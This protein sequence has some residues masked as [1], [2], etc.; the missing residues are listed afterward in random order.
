MFCMS[1]D[2][3]VGPITRYIL[4]D[5]DDQLPAA[6][7]GKFHHHDQ[8][9]PIHAAGSHNIKQQQQQQHDTSNNNTRTTILAT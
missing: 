8:A 9:I 1:R 2:P 4:T 6:A 5:S 3:E 7:T